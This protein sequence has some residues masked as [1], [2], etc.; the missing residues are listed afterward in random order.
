MLPDTS[1][2]FSPDGELTMAEAI[3]CWLN[4]AQSMQQTELQ[5]TEDDIIEV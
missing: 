3:Y 1:F 4:K 5:F 2:Y